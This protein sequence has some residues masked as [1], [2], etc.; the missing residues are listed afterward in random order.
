MLT[1]CN[2]VLSQN[3]GYIVPIDKYFIDAN[4]PIY[5]NV[6]AGDTLKLVAGN[7]RYIN[8]SNFKGAE[9][10]PIV[11]V[12]DGGEV[13]I[14]TDHY[15]GISIQN[16][17]YLKFT[18][19]GYAGQ[20][21]GFK[22]KKVTN[23]AGFSIGY[24]SSDIEVDHVSIENTKIGGLYAKTDPDCDP[25]SAR[26]SFTQYNTIIHDLYIANTGDE[27][28]YIGSTKYFGQSVNCNGKDTL[29]LPSILIGVKIF[30]NILK[31]TGWDGIQVSSASKNCQIYNNSIYY[32]SMEKDDTQMSGILIGGGTKC[33]CY[34]N[35]IYK[36]TGDGI[37]C[38]GLGGTRIFN[39]IIVEPGQNLYATDP[40]KMKHGIYVND[41]SVQRDSSFYIFNNNI[42]HPKTDGIRF[43]S[44]LSKNNYISANVIINPGSYDYYENGN[45]SYRGND[46]YIMF[47]SPNTNTTLAN[48]YLQ[49]DASSAGF[50]SQ[51]LEAP[52][53]FVLLPTSP[54]IDA[55]DYNV[56]TATT[57]D[58]YHHLRPFGPKSD[59]GAIE[60]EH[61]ATSSG[62]IGLEPPDS[63]SWLLQNPVSDLL[64]ICYEGAPDPLNKLEICNLQGMIVSRM[65]ESSMQPGQGRVEINVAGLPS[66]IYLYHLHSNNAGYTG[67]FIKR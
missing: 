9:G 50:I 65:E 40:T 20:F 17:R 62:Q 37:D 18:G 5:K 55:V 51:K 67:K 7:R 39:N 35:Y 34:N 21:Y 49:R 48:N 30:N 36:G 60:S 41:T 59:I 26:G 4:D 14:D 31:Y 46:S 47:Q 16:C 33:D 32:D 43:S 44:L 3:T 23:G 1:L 19:T 56:K 61:I 53:N 54:L 57:F 27:G 24:L 38:L 42:I 66:G 63:K 64:T 28:M 29:I 15:Y 22:V 58:F 10:K 12:N 8:L 52:A 45:T 2:G 11:V 6:H 25:R 13:I